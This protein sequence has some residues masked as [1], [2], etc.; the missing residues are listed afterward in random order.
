MVG[1]LKDVSLV[2]ESQLKG[3]LDLTLYLIQH[4]ET[5]PS[6]EIN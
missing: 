2:T 1:H 4:L 6:V 3:P 5:T